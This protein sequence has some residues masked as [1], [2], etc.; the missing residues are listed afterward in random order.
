MSAAARGRRIATIVL[1]LLLAAAPVAGLLPGAPGA[2]RADGI[3]LFWWYAAVIGPALAMTA[4]AV[5]LL[6]TRP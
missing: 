4:A 6:R 2:V 1:A 5:A 3:A